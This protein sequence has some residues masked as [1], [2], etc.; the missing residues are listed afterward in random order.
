VAGGNS[1][2]T[3]G[4]GSGEARRRVEDELKTALAEF[5]ELGTKITSL[6]QTR[7]GL[8]GL[9]HR[10]VE[11]DADTPIV[12]G[13]AHAANFAGTTMTGWTWDAI[14]PLTSVP[15]TTVV[16]SPAV[17]GEPPNAGGVKRKRAPSSTGSTVR[18]AEIIGQLGRP[19]NVKEIMEE[20]ERRS[21]LD[22][23][24]RT[25]EAAVAQAARR[26]AD[27]G[28]V[29]KLSTKRY[30]PLGYQAETLA[31]DCPGE[32]VPEEVIDGG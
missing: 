24:W 32:Q 18:V 9:L 8:A 6:R 14:N 17:T 16:T 28:L 20:F 23:S 21:W 2:R 30:G 7:R 27:R 3:V 15:L 4:A 22:P 11:V 10:P 1:P 26:A 31:S 12:S 13:S 19:L 25:P 5:E 29:A